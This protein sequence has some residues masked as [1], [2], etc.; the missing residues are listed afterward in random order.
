MIMWGT[1][2]RGA[3]CVMA[4]R[5]EGELYIIESQDAW[6]WPTAGIQRTP[7]AKWIKQ[8]DEASFNII[9]MP[10]SEASRAKFDVQKAQD[11]FFQ[12]EGL[13]YG[14][15][16]FLYGWMD[17]PRDNLPPSM[18]NEMIPIIFSMVEN[19]MPHSVYNIFVEAL[20]KRLGNTGC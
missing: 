12:T 4:L 3:H 6:Y 15:H 7:W 17:T 5:F 16:N 9:L 10:L 13:P 2:G 19:V 20:D 14:Y 11:W 18:P 8:A 1:G